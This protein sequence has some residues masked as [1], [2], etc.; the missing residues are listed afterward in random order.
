MSADIKNLKL[1]LKSIN[2][3]LQ[4][5][6]AMGLVA[7]SKIRRAVASMNKARAYEKSFRRIFLSLAE[8]P[9][10]RLSPFVKGNEGS[11][12]IILVM[13]DRGLAGGYNSAL[14]RLASEY[15]EAEIIPI[16]KKAGEKYGHAVSSEY[17]A[18]KDAA[19]LA[20][21][22]C[23]EILSGKTGR[24]SIIFSEYVNAMTHNATVTELF[25]VRGERAAKDIVYEP[26]AVSVFEASA[27]GYAA[28]VIFSAVKEGFACEVAARRN[29]MEAAKNNAEQMKEELTLNYNRARQGII[30]QEITEIVSGSGEYSRR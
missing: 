20:E 17:F 23:G 27:Q 18:F 14:L 21:K 29:A 3:T 8:N 10:C 30:T 2:S 12:K 16:G 24:V 19:E 11:H 5:T 25:P 7:S 15:K 13:G 1:R 22:L 6:G 4:L 9:E 26:D 28:S